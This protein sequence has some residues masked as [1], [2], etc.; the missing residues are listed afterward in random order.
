MIVP[1]ETTLELVLNPEI[2]L[3]VCMI[4]PVFFA[5]LAGFT[6]HLIK[7]E[8]KY[9]TTKAY[10]ASVLMGA[11]TYLVINGLVGSDIEVVTGLE[12]LTSTAILAGYVGRSVLP[13][14]ASRF[15]Q[16]FEETE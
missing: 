5:A 13:K 9:R 2:Y 1:G 6:A 7:S 8:K 3:Y 12:G 15:E 10:A 16:K 14:L 11:L 4:V